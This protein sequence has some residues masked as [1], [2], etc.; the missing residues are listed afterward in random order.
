MARFVWWH[1]IPG[2]RS[3]IVECSLCRRSRFSSSRRSR[4]PRTEAPCCP[5]LQPRRRHPGGPQ[6]PSPCR[7]FACSGSAG[8]ERQKRVPRT[9]TVA[10]GGEPPSEIG[11]AV[12]KELKCFELA[13]GPF[14]VRFD[15]DGVYEPPSNR[16]GA[17]SLQ[18]TGSRS[19]AMRA[20]WIGAWLLGTTRDVGRVSLEP[21]DGTR[22]RTTAD[23]E[24]HVHRR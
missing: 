23:P 14:T 24:D 11:S 15:S 8:A 5:Q 22:R 19:S 7:T 16:G 17:R 10:Y 21:Q 1:D 3:K 2:R 12:S 6:A 4:R 13:P 18:E 9:V 20:G